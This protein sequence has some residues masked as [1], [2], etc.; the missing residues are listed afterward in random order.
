MTPKWEVVT[1]DCVEHMRTLPENSVDSVVCDSPYDLL[2]SSRGGSGRQPGTAAPPFER[3]DRTGYIVGFADD[4]NIN[5]P[6]CCYC[7]AFISMS[8]KRDG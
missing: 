2:S 5:E 7:P 8:P 1:A 4:A 3:H 6:N